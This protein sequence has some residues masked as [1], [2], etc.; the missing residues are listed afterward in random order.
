LLLLVCLIYT[1]TAQRSTTLKPKIDPRVDPCAVC[2]TIA[3]HSR[4]IHMDEDDD[5]VLHRTVEVAKY[6]A[7]FNQY[8]WKIIM[9]QYWDTIYRKINAGQSPEEVCTLLNVCNR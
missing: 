6:V 9:Q 8:L 7:D 1:L 2:K 4:K 5:M 3:E